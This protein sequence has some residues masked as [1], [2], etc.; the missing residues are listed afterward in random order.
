MKQSWFP[1]LI[2]LPIVHYQRCLARWTQEAQVLSSCDKV[3][4]SDH[5]RLVPINVT[6][7]DLLTKLFNDQ[8]DTGTRLCKQLPDTKPVK[9]ELKPEKTEQVF[10]PIP[11]AEFV[12]IDKQPRKYREKFVLNKKEWVGKLQ[13]E[14]AVH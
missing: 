9:L 11:V 2:S 13:G 7:C 4:C 12:D 14:H 6:K 10:Q 5:D 1:G 8:K 3:H